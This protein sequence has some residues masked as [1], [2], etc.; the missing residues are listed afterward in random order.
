VID[1]HLELL[2]VG[3]P[4]INIIDFEYPYYHTIDDTEEQCSAES[5]NRVGT[6]LVHLIYE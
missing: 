1:D 3:I 6:L 4:A 5:L 2:K